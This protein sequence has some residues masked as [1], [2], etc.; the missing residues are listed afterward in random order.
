MTQNMTLTDNL[1][2]ITHTPYMYT[3][4]THEDASIV[5]LLTMC[6]HLVHGEKNKKELNWD[7]V[8][9]RELDMTAAEIAN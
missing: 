3:V 8:C 4:F 5:A 9:Q 1:N 7:G 2:N 6:L